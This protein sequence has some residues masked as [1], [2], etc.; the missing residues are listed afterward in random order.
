MCCARPQ[1]FAGC[2]RGA[3]RCGSTA[4]TTSEKGWYEL[5]RYIN[6]REA[7]IDAVQSLLECEALAFDIETQPLFHY[8]KERTKTAYRTYFTYLK[9]N[10][11]G[12]TYDPDASDLPDPLPQPVDVVAEQQRVQRLLNDA[13][14]A[15]RGK[16]TAARR[17][18]DL[19]RALEALEDEVAPRG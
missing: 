7:A 18:S 6:D 15:S 19:E 17:I 13:R 1:A 12:L 8:P 2:A 16:T 14:A 11:W 5:K 4:N 3:G 9:R 10:R